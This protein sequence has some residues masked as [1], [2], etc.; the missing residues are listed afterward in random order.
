MFIFLEVLTVINACLYTGI[1]KKNSQQNCVCV[2]Y[3]SCI[4]K[5]Q[6]VF[7]ADCFSEKGSINSYF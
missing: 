7:V 4:L 2:F 1:K 6:N 3:S 5:S